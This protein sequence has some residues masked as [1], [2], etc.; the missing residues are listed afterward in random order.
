M[1]P[2]HPDDDDLLPELPELELDDDGLPVE[3]DLGLEA[4]IDLPP[5]EGTESDDTTGLDEEFIH[6]LVDLP[7]DDPLEGDEVE[8][9]IPVEGLG[10]DDE[11][12]W[13]D[14]PRAAGGQDEEWDDGFELPELTPL[15]RDDGGE[16]GLDD[17]VQLGGS[18]D[19]VPHLPPLGD[20]EDEESEDIGIDDE[21]SLRS[22]DDEP[23]TLGWTLEPAACRV[24]VLGD[25]PVVCFVRGLAGG[26]GG[27]FATQEDWR[28]L[29]GVEQV[30]SMAVD[31][32][33]P[34]RLV[35]GTNTGALRSVDGGRTFA[36]A[37]GW[38][39][40]GR[41]TAQPFFVSCESSNRLWAR[42]ASGALYRSADFGAS[43]SGPL[44][45]K[46]VVALAADADGVVALCA[47]RNVP[48][49]VVHSEDGGQRWNASD[50]PPLEPESIALA[51]RRSFIA[52][53]SAA[54]SFL[55]ADRG[56]KWSRLPRFP[57]AAALAL[58]SEPRG[59]TVY[60]A[61]PIGG[62]LCV[63]RHRPGGGEPTLLVE[64]DAE[65]HA[66]HSERSEALTVLWLASSGGLHRLT[67][68]LGRVP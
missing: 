60:G 1:T 29:G 62:R 5:E 35:V 65:A 51:I 41:E 34:S 39:T 7:P 13:V 10:G 40:E 8:E 57:Q 22:F 42:T 68:D 56:K 31:P 30:L 36:P 16:E 54:G 4:E 37:N 6:E 63:V 49:Q 27:L 55:S 26:P 50:G 12:G 14:D 46:P 21:V 11:Y 15:T 9:E 20:D 52:V 38:A 66:L 19:E 43:W 23:M 61:H 18:G 2:S 33:E 45:L 59:I 48:P 25:K 53:S 32:Q 44:L 64:L 67:V 24:D 47:G 58:A 28:R 3:D 17:L